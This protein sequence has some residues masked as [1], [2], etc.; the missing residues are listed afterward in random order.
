M[1]TEALGVALALTWVVGCGSDQVPDSQTT[2]GTGGAG[3]SGPEVAV[4]CLPLSENPTE[5]AEAKLYVEYNATDGDVGV[6]GSFGDEGWSELCIFAPEGMQILGVEPRGSLGVLGLGTIFFESR[7]PPEDEFGFD[8]LEAAFPEGQYKVRGL[9]V[10]GGSF[11]GTANFTHD[12]PAPP[13]ITAPPLVPDFEEEMP[14]VVAAGDLVVEWEEVTETVAGAPAT[15]TAYE[16]IITKE[17][18][19]DPD[20]FSQPIFDVHVGPDQRSLTVP[21][22]FFETDTLY[23][24]E[25]LA[26]E[27]S[28]N[29]TITVGFFRSE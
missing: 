18:H 14:E 28:G 16:V 27:T 1:R 26:I 24:L 8:E 13:T 10:D 23:E 3:G 9:S 29:Q 20:A 15:I 4:D 6:H 11:I 2:Q 5:I 12:V 19:E 17:E 25:V 21:A 22:D 7:E